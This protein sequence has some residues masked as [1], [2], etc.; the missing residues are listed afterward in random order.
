MSKCLVGVYAERR[1]AVFGK[2]GVGYFAARWNGMLS[3]D[4]TAAY[5]YSSIQQGVSEELVD[6]SIR[7]E[8]I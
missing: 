2:G 7:D 6:E 5:G 8:I 3:M 4:C 1:C